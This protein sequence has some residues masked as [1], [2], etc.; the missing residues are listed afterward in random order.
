MAFNLAEFLKFA[1]VWFAVGGS[2]VLVNAFIFN[3]AVRYKDRKLIRNVTLQWG[4]AL[5]GSAGWNIV[6]GYFL[7]KPVFQP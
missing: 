6:L 4:L 5:L 3:S 2:G 7:T 1:V